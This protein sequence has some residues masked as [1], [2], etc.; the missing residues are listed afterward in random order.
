MTTLSKACVLDLDDTCFSFISH[1]CFM[2]Y[3]L[4]G[5]TYK[6]ED[7]SSWSLPA[8]LN[9]TFLDYENWIYIS[10]PI[11]PKV[12]STINKLRAAGYKIILMTARPESFKKHTEFNLAFNK[13]KYD[14]LY[15]NKNKSLKINRLAE[16]YDIQIFCDDKLDTV[17]KVKRET[18]VPHVY[19]INAPSNKNSDV[20]EGVV[21]IN[22]LH[23]IKE[24]E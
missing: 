15:F 7:L 10:Q 1:T 8:P 18:A 24:V 19:L 14:E 5:E 17:N 13:L 4:T 12:I 22:N 11:F 21:R 16:K 3:W 9:K 23:E 6:E 20:E 2:H